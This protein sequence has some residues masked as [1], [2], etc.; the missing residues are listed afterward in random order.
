MCSRLWAT[1]RSVLEELGD[2]R[3]PERVAGEERDGA[4]LA[5]R[6]ADMELA[7]ADADRV[8]VDE[9]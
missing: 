3:D 8:L 5:R 9:T 7:Y 4:D 6:D 1:S 2:E